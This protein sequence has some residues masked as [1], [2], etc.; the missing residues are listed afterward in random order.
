MIKIV[1]KLQIVVSILK[2]YYHKL[3][4]YNDFDIYFL[5][6]NHLENKSVR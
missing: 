1:Y 3:C 4:K 2:Y 5:S 6:D